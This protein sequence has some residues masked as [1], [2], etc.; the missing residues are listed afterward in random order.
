MRRWP[1]SL[2]CW[3]EVG[4]P[5]G[6]FYKGEPQSG[7]YVHP[8]PA[9]AMQ[10]NFSASR[11]VAGYSFNGH[12]AASNLSRQIWCEGVDDVEGVGVRLRYVS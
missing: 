3:A 12:R 10:K 9:V 8:Q 6:F 2:G 7:S 1:V 4:R 5:S 11:R